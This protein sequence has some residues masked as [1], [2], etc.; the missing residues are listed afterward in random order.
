MR[1]H[2][3]ALAILSA[4]LMFLFISDTDDV[5]IS[6]LQGSRVNQAFDYYLTDFDTTRFSPIGESEY[7][8]QADRIVHYPAPEFA[9]IESPRLVFYADQAGPWFLSAAYGTITPDIE[10]AE[11]RLDLSEN[12]LVQHI[13][14]QGQTYNI[15]ADELTIYLDSRFLSTETEVLFQA[16]DSEISSLGMTADLRTQHLTF[17]SNVRGRYE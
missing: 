8:L 1:N 7:R 3:I 13:D 6:V 12:V 17:L 14:A 10:R 4:L 11:D 9:S 15:Y 2:I 5:D 16:I